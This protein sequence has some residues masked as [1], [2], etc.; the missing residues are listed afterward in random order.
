MICIRDIGGENK[1][2][3]GSSFKAEAGSHSVLCF[4]IWLCV[5]SNWALKRPVPVVLSMKKTWFH[6]VIVPHIFGRL[7]LILAVL[8][9]CDSSK[10]L[11]ST[12]WTARNLCC[13]ESFGSSRQHTYPHL[14]EYHKRTTRKNKL[15]SGSVFDVLT[16]SVSEAQIVSTW[17]IRPTSLH[18]AWDR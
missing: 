2:A 1:K 14:K 17:R 4:W 16:S 18:W 7:R 3:F 6:V 12:M 10:G 9:K 5:C 15:I 8:I 11:L 13:S